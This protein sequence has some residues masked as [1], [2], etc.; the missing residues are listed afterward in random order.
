MRSRNHE[1]AARRWYPRNFRPLQFHLVRSSVLIDFVE[2]EPLA[3]E[4]DFFAVC[5]F[6]S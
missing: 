2:Q 5:P 3:V 4:V 1:A 6:D